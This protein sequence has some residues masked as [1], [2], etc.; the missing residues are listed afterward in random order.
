MQKNKINGTKSINQGDTL[1]Q[2][3]MYKENHDLLL[4][5]LFDGRNFD[6]VTFMLDA[7]ILELTPF[8]LDSLSVIEHFFNSQ[9]T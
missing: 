4:K 3:K 6:N 2:N 9:V 1:Q 5:S 8:E 7:V